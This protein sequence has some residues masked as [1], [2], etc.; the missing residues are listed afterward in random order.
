MDEDVLNTEGEISLS[1]IWNIIKRRWIWIILITTLSTLA[2]YIHV[3]QIVPLYRSTATLVV[4][5]PSSY[6]SMASS[7]MPDYYSSERWA[8]TYAEMLKGEPILQEVSRRTLHPKISPGE[9]RGG[10]SVEAVKN[11]LL[12]R[13]SFTYGMKTYAKKITDTICSV[14]IENISEFYKSNIQSSTLR[15]EKQIAQMEDEIELLIV[16]VSKIIPGSQE[17][18]STREE[19]S[20]KQELRSFLYQQYQSQKITEAQIMPSVKI[21]QEGTQPI[22]PVNKKFQLTMAIGFILGL[23]ISLLLA[24]FLEYLD[25]S[26]KTEEDLKK[27]SNRRILGVIPCFGTKKEGYYMGNYSRY[28]IKDKAQD[29]V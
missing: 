3:N 24:F 19:L 15:L 2:S 17:Y 27:L 16:K 7:P 25:D 18:D 21:F 9:L 14:F 28:Y 6:S 29:N 4:Q 23:F 20:R 1:D 13:V 10:L 11:T 5:T 22:A 8:Q 26:I 12:L